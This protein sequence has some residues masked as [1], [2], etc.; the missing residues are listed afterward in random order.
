ME[1]RIE[2]VK[3][4]EV[5]IMLVNEDS[6]PR[7]ISKRFAYGSLVGSA[8]VGFAIT[9]K[10]GKVYEFASKARIGPPGESDR[11]ELAPG[12]FVGRIIALERIVSDYRLSPGVYDVVA[13]YKTTFSAPNTWSEPLESNRMALVI[14]QPGRQGQVDK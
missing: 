5:H 7:I 3:G 4:S 9:D 10:T 12:Q 2:L 11:C 8:E 6:L 14:S 1:L 13:S